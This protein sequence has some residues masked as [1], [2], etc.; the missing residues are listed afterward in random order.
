MAAVAAAQGRLRR[1]TGKDGKPRRLRLPG[2]AAYVALFQ[3]YGRLVLSVTQ[4]ASRRQEYAAD[5]VAAGIAGRANAAS[6]LREMPAIEAAFSFYLN[7]Y[8]AAGLDRKILPPPA[9][10][11]GGF[12]ALLA[13]PTRQREM[14]ELR[15]DPTAEKPDPF[16]S[17]PPVLDR[18]AAIEGLPDDG[19]PVDTSGA[20]ALTV[21]ANPPAAMTAIGLRMLQKTGA[22]AQAVDWDTLANQTAA[23]RAARSSDPLRNATAKLYGTQVPLSGFLDAVDAGRLGEILDQMPRSDAAKQASATGRVAREFAKTSMAPMLYGWALAELA[24][25]GRVRWRNSW[26]DVGGELEISPELEA[27]LDKAVEAVTA[28]TPDAGQMR[29]VVYAMGVPA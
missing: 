26:A 20:R 24:A 23:E 10:V 28:V 15:R 4:E 6:A 9:E 25:Q 8:V 27:G 11:L 14:D 5:R 2:Q 3:A 21:L 7:R 22:G 17:H 13:E 16:D 19:R 18:I 1:D 12:A 29:A